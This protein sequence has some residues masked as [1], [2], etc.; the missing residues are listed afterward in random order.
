MNHDYQMSWKTTFSSYDINDVTCKPIRHFL[1]IK[2]SLLLWKSEK[3]IFTTL[4]REKERVEKAL[5][6]FLLITIFFFFF[7][8]DGKESILREYVVVRRKLIAR[9]TP[10]LE[11]MR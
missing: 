2:K 9:E 6:S 4:K 3:N 5:S 1:H 10:P 8:N 7:E 11:L